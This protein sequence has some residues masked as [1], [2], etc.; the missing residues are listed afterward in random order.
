MSNENNQFLKWNNK[1]NKT[2]SR[3]IKT[4]T[5]SETTTIDFKGVDYN[6]IA[7]FNDLSIDE[8]NIVLKR[9]VHSLECGEKGLQNELLNE[10]EIKYKLDIEEYQNK[11]KDLK[12]TIKDK[13]KNIKENEKNFKS[14]KK[15]IIR[16]YD[17]DI[18]ELKSKN[19]KDQKE[20]INDTEEK[21]KEQYKNIQESL[22]KEIELLKQQLLKSDKKNNSIETDLIKQ[23]NNALNNIRDKKDGEINKVRDNY[24]IKIV[25]MQKFH[26][27][28]MEKLNNTMR[29]INNKMTAKECRNQNS[30]LK[31]KDGE[32][33][34]H[35]ILTNIFQQLKGDVEDVHGKSHCGDFIVNI[36]KNNYMDRSHQIMFD[37]KNYERTVG[38]GEIV[39]LKNDLIQNPENDCGMLLCLKN[40]KIARADP[41]LD[42]EFIKVENNIKPIFYLTN[43]EEYPDIIKHAYKMAC[44]FMK[45]KEITINEE[46]KERLLGKMK[47]I[48]KM[49]NGDNKD[50]NEYYNKKKKNNEELLKM[51]NDIQIEFL[52]SD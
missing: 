14:E 20:I 29:E 24:E 28:E 39:K 16:D 9:G 49:L 43:V 40:Q 13:N 5:F 46:R 1:H 27:D 26:K 19:K 11:I 47:T 3:H 36:R 25:N 50:L 38:K 52:S 17:H 34:T 8:K 35:N 18:K 21:I 51:L 48:V 2:K 30:S 31:G 23:H 33:I 22:H 12:Q 6:L 42:F 15:D 4:T 7:I 41:P 45:N 37:A 32:N 44:L 10:K